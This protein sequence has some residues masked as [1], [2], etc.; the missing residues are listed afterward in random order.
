MSDSFAMLKDGRGNSTP[1]SKEQFIDL[2]ENGMDPLNGYT[3]PEAPPSPI[4]I[5]FVPTIVFSKIFFPP[6][7]IRRPLFPTTFTIICEN[8]KTFQGIAVHI[9]GKQKEKA[10]PFQS[11]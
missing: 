6:T 3:L 7:S 5:F 4:R 9:H 11:A 2:L 1:L 10:D 8:G